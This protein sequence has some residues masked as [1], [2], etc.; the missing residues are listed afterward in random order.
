M[1]YLWWERWDER[2]AAVSLSTL[3]GRW[4]LI[5]VSLIFAQIPLRLLLTPYPLW[6][7]LTALH[8]A[9][10]AAGALGAAW[11]WAGKPG[12]RWIGG[13]LLL[14]VST[15]PVPASI[16]TT[17]IGPL[18]EAMASLTAEISNLAGQP[19]LASGTSVRLASGWVGVDQACGGIRSLQACVMIA[20]FF[21]EWY[22]FDWGR[23]AK[24]VAVG[25]V[26]ALAGNL[27]RVLYLSFTAGSGGQ[28]AVDTAHDLAGW[29]AMLGSLALTAWLAC[30]W[31]GYRLPKQRHQ[32]NVRGSSAGALRWFAVV[33]VGVALA[34]TGSHVWYWR[35]QQ[36]TASVPRW[37]AQLPTDGPSYQV[38]P[39]STAAREML[40]PD[41]FAA[42]SWRQGE[43][44]LA[45]YYVEWRRGQAARS[46]PFLHNPTVCLPMSGC[47]LIDALPPLDVRW[48]LGTI[49]FHVYRFRRIGEDFIVAFTIWDP[50]RGAPLIRAEEEASWRDT[51]RTRWREVRSAR[52]HQPAQLLTVSITAVGDDGDSAAALSATIRDIVRT[53]AGL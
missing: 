25:A 48:A 8:T 50:T 47:E 40:R 23:R 18:R 35:G 26:A 30:R 51:W 13:P 53:E 24:L 14:T 49:R 37:T 29:S 27:A 2:P 6:P 5:A 39:L 17:M 4:W 45:A 10:M 15:L 36:A 33:T 28:D 9:A 31:A 38:A 16:E 12:V 11:L 7:A 3:S 20:L 46:I 52:K 1:L 34:E 32:S 19:A 22:R 42:G 21:G 43:L 41:A 44:T